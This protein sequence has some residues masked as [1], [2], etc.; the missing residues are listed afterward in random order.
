VRNFA[1]GAG[2]AS[3][4]TDLTHRNGSFPGVVKMTISGPQVFAR[5]SF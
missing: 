1:V 2:Y 5:F 4:R 3:I